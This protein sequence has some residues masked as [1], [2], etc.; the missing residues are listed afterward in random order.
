MPGA[1]GSSSKH[2]LL[3]I[4]FLKPSSNIGERRPKR[5][6]HHIGALCY[7][8]R[9][10][11]RDEAGRFADG[12]FADARHRVADGERMHPGEERSHIAEQ[13]ASC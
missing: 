9:C 11:S 13:R 2:D 10:K 12:R 8:S 6:Q 7:L 5:P 1:S 3:A 4:R